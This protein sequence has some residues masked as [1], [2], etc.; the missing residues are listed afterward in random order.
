MTATSRCD[1][2][3]DVFAVSDCLF[4]ERGARGWVVDR[5]SASTTVDELAV[6]VVLIIGFW[7]KGID[8]RPPWSIPVA[9]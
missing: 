2:V 8:R 1:G 9:L 5:N 4:G 7:I 3:V 6:D